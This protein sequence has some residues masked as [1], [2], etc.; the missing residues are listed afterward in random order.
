VERAWHDVQ[1]GVYPQWAK[2]YGEYTRRVR[3]TAEATVPLVTLLCG[4]GNNGGDGWVAARLLAERGIPV[5]VV[6]ARMP[7]ELTAQPARDAAVAA[8][9]QL[10]A[11]G[12]QVVR[13]FDELPLTPEGALAHTPLVVLA[14]GTH[15]SHHAVSR[16]ILLS[17]VVVDAILGTG[18]MGRVPR[19]PFI[20]WVVDA[21]HFIGNHATI[22]A[23]VPTGINPNTGE[24]ASPRILADETITMIVP[25]PGLTANECGRVT[26]APLAQIEPYISVRRQ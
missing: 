7:D 6:T 9:A 25:K 16:V 3:P 23:D 4:N 19:A 11:L 20:D 17:H 8:F 12:A 1:A 13:S 21:N 15:E 26:V 18:A 10:Q 14:G 2:D 22:A 24:S 5:A